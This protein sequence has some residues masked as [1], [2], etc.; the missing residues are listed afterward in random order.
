MA[1]TFACI[2]GAATYYVSPTGNDLNDGLS[3]AHPFHT[4]GYAVSVVPKGSAI[5]LLPGTYTGA[6]NVDL[7]VSQNV[8]ISSLG[9][10][11]NTVWDLGG[12]ALNLHRALTL[13]SGVRLDLSG[14]TIQN[15]QE[16]MSQAGAIDSEG[17]ILNIR[18]CSF[19]SNNAGYH[20]AGG[21][22]YING[23]TA[24][25]SNCLFFGNVAHFGGALSSTGH[26]TITATQCIFLHNVGVYSAGAG[27]MED[28]SN[29]NLTGCIFFGNTS[30]YGTTLDVSS[31]QITMQGCSI[32]HE[33]VLTRGAV[34]ADSASATYIYNCSFVENTGG[35]VLSVYGG[36]VTG[37]SF[38]DNHVSSAG[39]VDSLGATLILANDLFAN[40]Q[41]QQVIYNA[42][43]MSMSLCTVT[44]NACSTAALVNAANGRVSSCIFWNNGQSIYT[45]SSGVTTLTRTDTPEGLNIDPEFVSVP[46]SDFHLVANSPLIGAGDSGLTSS[47]PTDLDGN[48][49]HSTP[50]L[51]CYESLVMKP[52]TTAVGPDGVERVL[53]SDTNGRITLWKVSA[54]GVKLAQYVFLA[55][56]NSYP[57]ALAVGADNRAYL[58]FGSSINSAVT[59]FT[60]AANGTLS[61]TKTYTPATGWKFSSGSVSSDNALHL[62]WTNTLGVALF[63]EVSATG[64][65]T[66]HSFGA[67]GG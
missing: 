6:L 7:T 63:W 48:L 16:N 53:W 39:V 12:S 67:F 41:T 30:N 4:I 51:G 55:P 18:G 58:F 60:V 22:I 37:C 15:G 31:S 35:D 36:E 34:R 14:I 45:G 20:S 24:S 50:T 54:S 47:Y 13:S 46:T 10:S 23:G 52:V 42:G 11:T 43:D 40:N 57:V 65:I 64:T 25:L 32:S 61:S 9:T 27:D 33:S 56:A 17:G 29:V 1:T 5:K 62:M 26:A 19:K 21:A 8:S 59:V 44:E 3:L 49:R 38:T 28:G 2:S 66:T